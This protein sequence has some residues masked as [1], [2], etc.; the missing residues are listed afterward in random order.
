[1][2][3]SP[4]TLVILLGTTALGTCCGLVGALMLLRRRALLA[5]AIAHSTLPGIC[6]AFLIGGSRSLPV[7]G[8]GALLSALLAAS[9]V[10]WLPRVT[11]IRK[12][13]A[14]ACVLG[15]MFG[16]GIALVGIIQR[17]G[18][19]GSAAGLDGLLLGRTAGMLRSEA[20]LFGISAVVMS[21]IIVALR[22]ELLVSCFDPRFG[23]S[24]KIPARSIDLL[25]T[26]LLAATIVIALPAV[27]VVL[28]AALVIIP[29]AAARFWTDRFDGLLRTSAL[30]G[31]ASGIVGTLI[32]SLHTNLPAGPV[33]VLSATTFFVIS[34][35][36]APGR[37]WISRF[38][39]KRSRLQNRQ[40]RRFL[41]GIL[42]SEL[43]GS[44][45][46]DRQRLLRASTAQNRRVLSNSIRGGWVQADPHRIQLTP[47]GRQRAVRARKA[48]QIWR[49]WLTSE[50]SIDRDLIDLDEQDIEKILPPDLI[51]TLQ[52]SIDERGTS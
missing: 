17:S 26:S 24:S 11:R 3:I 33:I 25:Q 50:A 44:T 37:G 45:E 4:N 23:L 31:A 34:L 16:A 21:L 42:S 48:L 35:L 32:S 22:K 51:E 15:I 43:G 40:L 39:Q 38:L 36:L 30:L 28:T 47:V 27:G 10:S 19:S 41:D 52:K 29:A 12:D 5:D 18:M 20:W 6:I 1:M 46:V 7:L 8:I 9:L 13:A 2:M 49:E 14:T